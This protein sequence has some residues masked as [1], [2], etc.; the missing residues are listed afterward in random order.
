M[1]VAVRLSPTERE[2]A[3]HMA[4][5]HCYSEIASIIGWQPRSVRVA[6]HRMADKLPGMGSPMVK[7]VRWET[8]R[9]YQEEKS[10]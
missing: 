2:I 3:A 7:I 8:Q 6:V 9:R 4:D 1:K 10:A 5:G